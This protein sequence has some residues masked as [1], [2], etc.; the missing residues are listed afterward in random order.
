MNVIQT[1]WANTNSFCEAKVNLCSVALSILQLRKFYDEVTLYTD[2]EGTSILIDYLELPYTKVDVSLDNFTKRFALSRKIWVSKKIYT[3]S[4]QNSP[5]IH[6]DTDVFIWKAFDEDL[7]NSEVFGQNLEIGFDQYRL[8]HDELLKIGFD[9]PNFLLKNQFSDHVPIALNAGIVGGTNI[10]FF[11][12]YSNLVLSLLE[13]DRNLEQQH[14]LINHYLEQYVLYALAKEKKITPL[15]FI[16]NPF[17]PDS[18]N[19]KFVQFSTVPYFTDYIHLMRNKNENI[20]SIESMFSYLK[21]YHNSY[22]LKIIKYLNRSFYMNINKESFDSY[23]GRNILNLSRDLGTEILFNKNDGYD[24]KFYY[25][26]IV[27]YKFFFGENS[28]G[29]SLKES[30]INA[31]NSLDYNEIPIQ[32]C[33]FLKDIFSFESKRKKYINEFYNFNS[34]LLNYG[35]KNFFDVKLN[36]LLLGILAVNQEACLIDCKWNWQ[37]SNEFRLLYSYTY[38]TNLFKLEE[39]DF[40][41]VI[42]YNIE[43]NT[44]RELCLDTVSFSIV[45]ILRNQPIVFNELIEIFLSDVK[46]D[47]FYYRELIIEHVLFLIHHSI[48]TINYGVA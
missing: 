42:L 15:C 5:F 24:D 21:N 41:I 31:F 29:S 25:R 35:R 37:E 38:F 48:L 18:N 16:K 45:E 1:Y 30:V 17:Y 27:V 40:I 39:K 3:Y 7:V 32:K 36:T 46:Q 2:H 33:N 28:I 12:E 11:K 8:I 20:S 22:Y 23:I 43:T 19:S 9:F 47:Y 13:N 14:K 4:L 44:F 6:I 10:S 26:S 34:N